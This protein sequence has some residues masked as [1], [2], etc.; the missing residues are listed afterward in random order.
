MY[1]PY[2]RRSGIPKRRPTVYPIPSP[3]I[4]PAAAAS[5]NDSDI[6]L[7]GGGGQESSSNKDRLS[8]KGHAGAF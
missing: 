2:L 1:R 6:D 3:T 5:Y 7:I 8:G 4:A